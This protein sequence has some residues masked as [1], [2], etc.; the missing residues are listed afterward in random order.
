[1]AQNIMAQSPII[2]DSDSEDESYD[3]PRLSAIKEDPSETESTVLVDEHQE[4]EAANR[5]RQMYIESD[6]DSNDAPIEIFKK[7]GSEPDEMSENVVQQLKRS[8]KDFD[9]FTPTEDL[10]MR[11]RKVTRAETEEIVSVIS[12][13]ER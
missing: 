6:S 1:M 7:L 10:C 12:E 4:D 2:I 9:F 3:D 8:E 11:I 13:Y 5:L